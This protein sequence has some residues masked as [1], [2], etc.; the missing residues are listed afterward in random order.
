MGK[1]NGG[2][3]AGSSGTIYRTKGER[4]AYS[5]TPNAG[6]NSK[7]DVAEENLLKEKCPSAANDAEEILRKKVTEVRKIPSV[8]IP[9]DVTMCSPTFRRIPCA[10]SAGRHQQHEPREK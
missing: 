4:E 1:R 6:G 7:K 5:P 10:K 8:V 3:H 9:E 2:L